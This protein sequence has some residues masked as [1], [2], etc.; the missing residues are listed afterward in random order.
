MRS[1]IACT[2]DSK[3]ETVCSDSAGGLQRARGRPIKDIGK[4]QRASGN[5][6]QTHNDAEPMMAAF[7]LDVCCRGYKLGDSAVT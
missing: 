4:W 1:C 3:K 2:K 7:E 5:A 6:P